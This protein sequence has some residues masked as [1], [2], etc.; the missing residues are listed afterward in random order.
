MFT[1]TNVS[2][3]NLFAFKVK[4]TNSVKCY[5]KNQGS[6]QGAQTNNPYGCE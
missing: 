4:L 6:Q 3:K 2:H 5:A 1:S